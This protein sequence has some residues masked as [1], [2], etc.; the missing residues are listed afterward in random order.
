MKLNLDAKTY[1]PKVQNSNNNQEEEDEVYFDDEDIYNKEVQVIVKD[2]IENEEIEDNDSDEDKWFPKYKD[3]E[4]CQGFVYKCNETTC[5][6]LLSCYCK[7][8]TECDDNY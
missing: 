5:Q 6:N 2:I 3:C 1:E 8:K 4:C 7:V